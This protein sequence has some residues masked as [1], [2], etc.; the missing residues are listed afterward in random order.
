MVVPCLDTPEV[1]MNEPVRSAAERLIER[2]LRIFG[3]I[4]AAAAANCVT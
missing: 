3:P 4:V 1:L 2:Q